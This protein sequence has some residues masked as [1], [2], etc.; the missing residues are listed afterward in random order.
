MTVTRWSAAGGLRN[1]LVLA[2]AILGTCLAQ[3]SQQ[4]Y[5]EKLTS[6]MKTDVRSPIPKSLPGTKEMRQ[7]ICSAVRSRA[8][9]AKEIAASENMSVTSAATF[10]AHVKK[11]RFPTDKVR[12]AVWRD[13][14]GED[15]IGIEDQVSANWIE[16]TP[17]VDGCFWYHDRCPHKPKVIDSCKS[18]K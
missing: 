12:L 9:T 8:D 2:V 3:D 5:S 18:V 13:E 16:Y 14:Q 7:R 6:L 11:R 15:W 17:F 10:E 4:R 1:S